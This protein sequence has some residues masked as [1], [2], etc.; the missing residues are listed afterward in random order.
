MMID[1]E[2]YGKLTGDKAAKIVRDIRKNL[3]S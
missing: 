2:T 1:G 3:I